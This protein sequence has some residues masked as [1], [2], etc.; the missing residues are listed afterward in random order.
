MFARSDA[1]PSLQASARLLTAGAET[2]SL[3]GSGRPR[4]A[5]KPSRAV[6]CRRS[7]CTMRL[8]GLA[9][10]SFASTAPYVV[11][12]RRSSAS[13]RSTALRASSVSGA[14]STGHAAEGPPIAPPPP[15]P[16]PRPFMGPGPAP[17]PR[18]SPLAARQSSRGHAGPGSV[19]VFAQAAMRERAAARTGRRGIESMTR[20]LQVGGQYELRRCCLTGPF[21]PATPSVALAGCF[22]RRRLRATIAAARWPPTSTRHFI[23]HRGASCRA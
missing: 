6:A 2:A 23:A 4:L 17:A 16:G 12:A 14:V 15:P 7:A 19:F 8:K 13:A 5:S 9:P 20:K 22:A 11:S 18:S 1:A 3:P 10:P 21:R